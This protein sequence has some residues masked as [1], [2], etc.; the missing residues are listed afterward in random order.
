LNTQALNETGAVYVSHG[1][2]WKPQ[3][4]GREAQGLDVMDEN[5]DTFSR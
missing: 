1:K 4:A 2:G 3:R 5:I